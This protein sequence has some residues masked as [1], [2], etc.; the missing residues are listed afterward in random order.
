MKRIAKEILLKKFETIYTT[1]K[2]F[3]QQ[4]TRK[5]SQNERTTMIIIKI[6][7]E[8]HQ[9]NICFVVSFYFYFY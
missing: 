9:V 7:R 3:R 5:I 6:Q 2:L 8:T 1:D 4:Q